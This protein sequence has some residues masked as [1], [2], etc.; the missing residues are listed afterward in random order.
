MDVM[1]HHETNTPVTSE[2]LVPTDRASRY[3]KQ[4]ASHLGRKATSKW[5]EEA[6]SGS[7]VFGDRGRAELMAEESGLRMRVVASTETVEQLEGVLGRHLV[8]FGVRDELVVS[9]TR[10]DGTPGTEQRND[11]A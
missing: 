11:E 4:L 9:W 10:S 3:G 5:D 7:V 6:G 2:S 1:T 8:R